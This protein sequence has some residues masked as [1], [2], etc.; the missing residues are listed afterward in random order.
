M[1]LL[2]CIVSQ[3]AIYAQLSRSTFWGLIT[4]K[5]NNCP[6]V[7]LIV[8]DQGEPHFSVAVNF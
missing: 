2:L 6:S 5:L 7:F 3:G 8:R 1:V 4:V